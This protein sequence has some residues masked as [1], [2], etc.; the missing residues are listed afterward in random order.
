MRR[1][2]LSAGTGLCLFF[3]GALLFGVLMMLPIGGADMP[4]VIAIGGDPASIY[5]GS[6]PLPPGIDEFLFAGFIRRQHV[7][8]AKALTCDLEVPAEADVAFPATALHT[9]TGHAAAT[10]RTSAES[11]R[12][13]GAGP[14][15]RSPACLAPRSS[16]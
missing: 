7:E 4:V 5:S 16:P 11:V 6:A 8:L 9:I 13:L 2:L 1:A 12:R 14:P 15:Y 10:W 3:A